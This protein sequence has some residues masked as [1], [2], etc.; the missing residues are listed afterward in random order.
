MLFL[1]DAHLI[2]EQ[3]AGDEMTGSNLFHAGIRLG[4]AAVHLLIAAAAETAVILRIDGTGHITAQDDAFLLDPRV[5]IGD[6]G[7]ER[8]GV[9]VLWIIVELLFVGDLDQFTQIHDADAVADVFDDIEAV[10]D[11]EIGQAEF[12]FE[13][14]EQIEHLRLDRNVQCRDGLVADDE[15]R[16]HSQGAGNADTLPLAAGKFVRIA[17]AVVIGQ[18]DAV[19]QI[20]DAV[21]DLIIGQQFI[22]A[23]GFS[24]DIADG[25]A[26]I[27][28]RIGILEDQLDIFAVAPPLV[29]THS[30]EVFALIDDLTGS[31]LMQIDDEFADGT[32]AGDFLK[33]L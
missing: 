9:R 13:V 31:G 23:N 21:F 17:V 16:L 14:I 19:E 30:S 28:G 32:L 5:D 3:M 26:R 10:G 12:F 2:I 25:H 22:G 33:D 4:L 27:E 1:A 8:F 15:L 24:N 7:E 18:A 20:V 6:R 29:F 11:E